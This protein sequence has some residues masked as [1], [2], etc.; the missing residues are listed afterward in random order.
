MRK[1]EAGS[2]PKIRACLELG[3]PI[4]HGLLKEVEN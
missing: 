2:C 4:A 3:A 1:A